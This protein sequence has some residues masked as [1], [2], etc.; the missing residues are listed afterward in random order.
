[1]ATFVAFTSLA[2]TA[3]YINP[4]K[5]SQVV[6]IPA[7]FLPTGVAAGCYVDEARSTDGPGPRRAVQG[8]IATVVAALASG[9]G[10]GSGGSVVGFAVVDPGSATVASATGVF[11]GATVVENAPGDATVTFGTA[12]PVGSV[13]LMGGLTPG[14]VVTLDSPVST[15][16]DV[17]SEDNAGA[18]ASVGFIVVAFA[19]PS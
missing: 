12:P 6:P 15:S 2:G 9:S 19:P 17:R 18:P 10:S 3:V 16:F 7:G 13:V 8:D 4:D 14:S 5:V 11:D 1:M